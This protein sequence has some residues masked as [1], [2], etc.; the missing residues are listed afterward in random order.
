MRRR[1]I[2]LIILSVLITVMMPGA[3][4]ADPGRGAAVVDVRALGGRQFEY[5]VYSAAMDRTVP[6]W[7]SHPE[8]AAPALYLLNAIDGGE[9]GVRGRIGPMWRS[10]SPISR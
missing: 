10:S 1:S 4:E 6:V 8:G 3:S 7:V 5:L 9:A 2:F